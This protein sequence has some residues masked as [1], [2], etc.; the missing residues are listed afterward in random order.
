[1]ARIGK[2]RHPIGKIAGHVPYAAAEG[3]EWIG[4]PG[5]GTALILARYIVSH[6][7]F[8]DVPA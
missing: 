7:S 8:S 3:Q 2:Y 5:E 6:R 1:L 4:I